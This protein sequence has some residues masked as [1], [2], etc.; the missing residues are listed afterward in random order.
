V[1]NKYAV[2]AELFA[3]FAEQLR[4]DHDVLEIAGLLTAQQTEARA[5]PAPARAGRPL[6]PQP[7]LANLGTQPA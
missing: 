7:R 3:E 2:P 6:T 4:G 1:D 5:G